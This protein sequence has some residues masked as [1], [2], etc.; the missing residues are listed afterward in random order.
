MTTRLIFASLFLATVAH[1]QMD[2]S[3]STQKLSDR[4]TVLYGAGGNV[5][6]GGG[7]TTYI[8][9]D[10]LQPVTDKV[11]AEVAK[12]SKG[13]IKFVI[14]TH[15]HGDHTGGNPE[16]GKDGAVIVAHDNVRKR[17]STDQFNSLFKK[18]T[19]ASPAIALPVVTFSDSVTLHLNGDDL[20]VQHVA[21]AHTDGDSIIW[22]VKDDVVHMGDCYFTSGYPFVDVGSGGNLD[23]YVAAAEK[24]LARAKDSTRIIPGHGKVADK[25]QLKTWH[26]ML[27]TVRDRVKKAIKEGKTLDQVQEMKPT[28]EFDAAWGGGFIKPAMFVQMAYE[29]YS[30]RK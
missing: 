2:M 8:V 28:A 30:P 1:A 14:N 24:V 13:P 3:L 6:I 23:G 10:K 29:S 27:T 16:L 12:V 4:L 19:P 18:A 11:K 25:K 5:A 9:D 17:L 7:E 22:W 20:E 15:W 21:P 26:D